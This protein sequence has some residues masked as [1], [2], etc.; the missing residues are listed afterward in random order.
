VLVVGSAGIDYTFPGIPITYTVDD[1]GAQ[2]LVMITYE[3]QELGACCICEGTCIE[4]MDR[5]SCE[6]MPDA[7]VW[8]PGGSCAD[9]ACACPADLDA[10]GSVDVADLLALLAAW[11]SG[12]PAA[13]F[14]CDAVVN[15]TDLLLLLDAWGGC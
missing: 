11:G 10:S 14:N 8:I 7:R 2:G 12:G 5:D 3:Y 6:A 15:T 4:G 1:F 13:D 9:G